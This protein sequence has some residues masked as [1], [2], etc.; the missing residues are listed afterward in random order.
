VGA[1]TI[2]EQPL[3]V[4]LTATVR[5]CRPSSYIGFDREVSSSSGA[6]AA[7]AA[8]AVAPALMSSSAIVAAGGE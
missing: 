7:A 8:A 4:G 2:L 1:D 3:D 5:A 6:A